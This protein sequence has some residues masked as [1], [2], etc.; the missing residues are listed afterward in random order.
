MSEGARRGRLKGLPVGAQ[1]LFKPGG[2]ELAK[3]IVALDCTRPDRESRQRPRRRKC[4][5][6]CRKLQTKA[7]KTKVEIHRLRVGEGIFFSC[8]FLGFFIFFA[9]IPSLS[10]P[11]VNVVLAFLSSLD[12]RTNIMSNELHRVYPVYV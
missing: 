4:C 2:S 10:S 12:R 11:Y 9:F 3:L 7:R 5:F 8:R 1:R 6:T